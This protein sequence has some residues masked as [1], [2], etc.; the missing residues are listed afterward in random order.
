M[1]AVRP[2][3]EQMDMILAAELQAALLPDSCPGECGHF[4]A[5][6]RN[7]MCGQVGGDFH[8]F[9]RVNEDQF[10]LVVGDVVGHGVRASLLMAQIMGHL[11][12][13]KDN[14]TRPAE[15]IRDLNRM[16]LDLG[17]R[18]DGVTP[19][20]LFYAAIDLPT[21]TGFFVNAGHPHPLLSHPATGRPAP[22]ASHDLLLGVEEYQPAELCY[23]FVPGQRLVLYTDGVVDA[24]DP[25]RREFGQHRLHE[26]VASLADRDADGCADGVFEAVDRFR[27]GAPQRDDETVVVIDRLQPA[28]ASPQAV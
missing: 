5:A 24:V 14:L 19:C 16:L 1:R 22:L 6:A 18:I 23:R 10:V 20:T 15:M 12:S 3:D 26:A 17:E 28:T 13:G 27:R 8:D 25:D 9:I 4:R 2:T 7:R 11:R 21:G